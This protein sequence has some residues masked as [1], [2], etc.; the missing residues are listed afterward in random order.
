MRVVLDA[1]V[2]V[3]AFATR[4]LCHSVLEVCL[5]RC[6]L[7]TGNR[8]VSETRK[9]LTEKIKLP[10][11][12]VESV[13]E[14]LIK[15]AAAVVASAVSKEVCRDPDDLEILGLADSAHAQFL[16]TGDSDLLELKKYK[17]TRIVTPRQFW[18]FIQE[19]AQGK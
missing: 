4:G 7:F 16:V 15:N 14:F 10:K 12:T 18:V 6:D 11:E 3:A 2:L 9:A 17:D 1:N 8:I 5:D 13:G 19:E